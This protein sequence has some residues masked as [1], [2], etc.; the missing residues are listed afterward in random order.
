[1]TALLEK[2]FSLSITASFLMVAVMV[3]RLLLKKSPKGM[4]YF[5]WAMVGLRLILPFEI[6]SPF[7][8]LPSKTELKNVSVPTANVSEN[9]IPTIASDGINVLDVLTYVWTTGAV[10]MLLYML[11]SFI[12]V[13]LMVRESVV[14]KDGI[15]LCDHVRSPFVLGVLNPKIYLNSSMSKRDMKLIIA[16]E[17]T[18]I[19][20]GDNIWKPL[21]FILLSIYWFN[22]LCWVSYFLFVKDIELFCDESVVK[23]LSKKGKKNYSYALLSCSTNKNMVTVCPLAFAENSVKLRVRNILGY[24]KPAVYIIAVSV[25]LC[26]VTMLMFMTHP[27]SAKEVE[28]SDVVKATTTAETIKETTVETTAPIVSETQASTVASTEKPTE[29]Q[30][31]IPTNQQNNN[32]ITTIPNEPQHSITPPVHQDD[33]PDV[34]LDDYVN[35]SDSN[36]VIDINQVKENVYEGSKNLIVLDHNYNNNILYKKD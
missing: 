8:V 12:R 29:K 24:K 34:F 30:A 21:G 9:T 22:P 6:E 26:V 11:I 4:R 16:H 2:I 7:S 25:A 10:L 15:Y 32:Q 3:L 13:R 36:E 14:Y 18:H 20:H 17:R 27:V 31:Q 5:L 1:M 35:S 28:K 23:T 19:K 33:N